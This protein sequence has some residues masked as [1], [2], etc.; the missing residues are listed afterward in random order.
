MHVRDAVEAD[1]EALSSIAD[2]PAAAMRG[3]VHDRTVRVAVGEAD[4]TDPNE[5]VDAD[6]DDLLG[7]VS[8][9]AHGET[10][11]VTQFGGTREAAERL[12]GEPLRFAASEG[13]AVEL[14]VVEGESALREA[15]D[16]AGF[17]EVGP[18]PRFDG[19]ETT[20]YRVEKA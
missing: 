20:R 7:F 14:L 2:A 3:L 10:V 18:G 8:F 5:D 13:M 4:A 15:A 16:A 11:H 17:E 12:L 19:K 1:A 6:P 9:D